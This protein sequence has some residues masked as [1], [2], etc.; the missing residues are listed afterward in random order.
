MKSDRPPPDPFIERRAAALKAL[1][2]YSGRVAYGDARG[3]VIDVLLE[4]SDRGAILLICGVLEDVLADQIIKKLPSGKKHKGELLRLGGVLGSFPDKLT[5]GTALNVIDDSTADSLDIIRQ[6]RNACAHTTIAV[7]LKTPEINHV[8]GLMLDDEH[9]E[10]IKSAKNDNYLRFVLGLVMIY[11]AERILGKTDAEAQ[12]VVNRL[13]E[14]TKV[15]VDE[16]VTRRAASPGKQSPQ[17][18]PGD[19]ESR[20]D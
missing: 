11:H 18:D 3:S 1:K 17:S 15:A 19:P 2:E 7:T 10:Y 13:A 16:E 6:L 5:L 4:E 12:A 9:A 20:R 8:I 14:R